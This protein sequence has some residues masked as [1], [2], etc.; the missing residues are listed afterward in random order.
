MEGEG[1]FPNW[2]KERLAA[3]EAAKK[4]APAG[5]A[6][7]KK[8]VSD[9]SSQDIFENPHDVDCNRTNGFTHHKPIKC[10]EIKGKKISN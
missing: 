7:K 6:D 1:H 4:K 3:K 2:E 9:Q 10:P 5:K 8:S